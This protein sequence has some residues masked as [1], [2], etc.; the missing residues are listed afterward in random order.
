MP[1]LTYLEIFTACAHGSF[2][3]ARVSGFKIHKRK[4]I[5]DSGSK[6][7]VLALY[8]GGCQN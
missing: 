3:K 6:H 4:L 5:K 1:G 7:Q 2:A 8:M